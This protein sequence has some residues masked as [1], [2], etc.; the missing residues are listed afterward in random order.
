MNA[1]QTVRPAVTLGWRQSQLAL[2]DAGQGDRPSVGMPCTEAVRLARGTLAQPF[3]KLGDALATLR[4]LSS[5][6]VIEKGALSTGENYRAQVRMRL[7]TAQLPRPFQ[8]GAVGHA[9]WSIGVSRNVRLVFDTNP[10]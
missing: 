8:I 2:A 9:D 10:R 3:D 4:R 6:T 7:D 1:R 5:W